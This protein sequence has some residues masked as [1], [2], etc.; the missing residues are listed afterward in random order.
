[1][2]ILVI[3][4]VLKIMVSVMDVCDVL[5]K[6]V[7]GGSHGD[8]DINPSLRVVSEVVLWSWTVTNGT[9]AVDT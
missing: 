5:V 4:A 6:C 1:M 9:L 2:C 7:G 8:G 3:V